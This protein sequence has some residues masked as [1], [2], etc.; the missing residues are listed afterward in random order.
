[1]AG[2]PGVPCPCSS[3]RCRRVL[4]LRGH[5]PGREI[6]YRQALFRRQLQLSQQQVTYF[7]HGYPESSTAGSPAQNRRRAGADAGAINCPAIFLKRRLAN[8]PEG[9]RYQCAARF[10]DVL[11]IMSPVDRRVREDEVRFPTVLRQARFRCSG[12]AGRAAD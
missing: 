11:A 8:C 3:A 9:P 5:Q 2:V 6:I 12:T 10:K 7:R 1:V 4:G